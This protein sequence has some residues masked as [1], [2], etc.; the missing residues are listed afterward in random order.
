MPDEP[1][2]LEHRERKRLG[3]GCVVAGL[4]FLPI[5]YALSPPFVVPIFNLEPEE[6]TTVYAPL[7]WLFENFEFVRNFYRW[8]F[9]LFGL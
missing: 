5:L 3:P 2:Q 7:L 4:F 9:D 8:Y 1:E 6:F